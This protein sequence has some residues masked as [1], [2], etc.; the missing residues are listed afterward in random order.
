MDG[1]INMGNGL[2]KYSK[3]LIFA[4]AASLLLSIY[5]LSSLP[6]DLKFKAN[7]Q[8]MDLANPVLIKLYLALGLTAVIAGVTLYVEMRNKRTVIVYKEKT[9]AQAAE[10]KSNA[11]SNRAIDALT[12]KSITAKDNKTILADALNLLAKSLEAGAGAC[13]LPGEENG[14]RYIELHTGFALPVAETDVVRFNPGEGMV[15]QVAKSGTAIFLDEIPEGYFQVQSGLG[16]ASPKYVLVLPV[17]KGTEIK[18]VIEV[19]TFKNIG[20]KE[21]QAVEKFTNEI[22]ERLS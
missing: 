5:L 6:S 2:S 22:G 1:N 7:V 15:G 14:Q 8:F 17:K 19:A 18:A 12:S 3:A 9:Q 4:F 10:E 16:Q 21:R 13:Y 20:Q 11:D